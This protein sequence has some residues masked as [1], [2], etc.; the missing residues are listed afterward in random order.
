M[1]SNLFSAIQPY[2]L[3]IMPQGPAIGRI[4]AAAVHAVEPGPAVERFVSRS[5][6]ILTIDGR[7]YNLSRFRRVCL[8]WHERRAG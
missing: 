1:E 7:E 5:G 6:D 3:R 2:S 4:L 8:R